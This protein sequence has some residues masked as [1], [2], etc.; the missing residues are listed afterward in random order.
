MGLPQY[1]Y[2]PERIEDSYQPRRDI[3][4]LAA[5]DCAKGAWA[6]WCVGIVNWWWESVATPTELF[7][8]ALFLFALAL[9]GSIAVAMRR[10]G[11]AT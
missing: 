3:L 4:R 11:G 2:T 10:Q 6:I 1:R 8:A 9:A 5:N 7:A